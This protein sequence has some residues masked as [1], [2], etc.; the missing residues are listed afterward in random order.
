MP[1][2][3]TRTLDSGQ[4]V[5]YWTRDQLA[6]RFSETHSLKDLANGAR[7]NALTAVQTAGSGHI[8]TSLSSL[9]IMIAAR[10]FLDGEDF[11]GKGSTERIFFSSKGHD[12]PALYATMHVCGQLEDDDIFRLRRLGGLPGHPETIT[13]GVPTNTGSL[14][15]GISKAKGFIKA[16]RLSAPDRRDPVIVM[17]GDGELHE[18]QIWESLPGAVRDGFSELI[19]IVDGNKIQSDTWV[20]STLPL[21]NLRQRVEG[22]GWSYLECDGQ[23]PDAVMEAF[24][25]AGAMSTPTFIYASTTK[26]SGVPWMESFPGDGEY[27]KFH[28]GALAPE[29]YQA[30]S[31]ILIGLWGANPPSPAPT[32]AE[33]RPEF[34]ALTPRAR[35]ESMLTHWETMIGEVMAANPK[36]VALDGDLSYDTGTHL[37]RHVFPDRYIQAGIAEQDMVS[38]AGTLALSD[39][40]PFVHSFATFLTMRATEQIFN[41]ATEYTKIVYFGFLAGIVPSAPGFSHQAVTDVGIMSSIP[42]MRVF[43]PSCSSELRWVI[44]QALAHDG[45]SFIRMGGLVPL[46]AAPVKGVA[47][48]VERRAGTQVAFVTSGPLL[49]HEAMGAAE[50]LDMSGI[51]AAV[52]SYPEITAEPNP[53]FVDQLAGFSSVYVLENHNPTNA[54][55]R[56]LADALEAHHS[57]KVVRIGVDGIPANGQPA[58]VLEHHLLDAQSIAANVA[59]HENPAKR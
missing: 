41:N 27:Y 45:P 32:L 28:S 25:Q 39:Y 24:T 51:D 15:M 11:V 5:S 30:A 55:F 31:E 23:D 12:A 46:G 57:T 42:G 53:A 38:M 36:V 16:R 19:A 3:S 1:T 54:K 8:G 10:R 26:G 44:D 6:D 43:E 29:V 37:V 21:G 50:I 49:G 58:E 4:V 56:R 13:P 47:P 22:S 18:G 35:P 34:D 9:D 20:E 48:G 59:G 2:P 52:F 33:D 14:G 40:V 17:L 7:L